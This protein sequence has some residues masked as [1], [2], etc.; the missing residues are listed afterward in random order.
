MTFVSS[1]DSTR[2]LARI[3]SNSSK[4]LRS[5]K[6]LA[7]KS[8]TRPPLLSSAHAG[9]KTAN[10]E[11][12]ITANTLKLFITRSLHAEESSDIF[13]ENTFP[14]YWQHNTINLYTSQTKMG[15]SPTLLIFTKIISF[16]FA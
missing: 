12:T 3:L 16:L 15:Y 6:L 11:K 9:V 8:L 1:I 4:D 5:F 10:V 13:S 14:M 7:L 2:A